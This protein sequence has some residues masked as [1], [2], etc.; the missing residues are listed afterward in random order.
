MADLVAEV[1]KE[2]PIRLAHLLPAPLP[3]S[4]IGFGDIDR[5]EAVVVAGQHPGTLL[6]RLGRIRKKIEDETVGSL[7]ARRERQRSF[8]SV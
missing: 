2:R 6:R 3:L 8:K 4:I 5:D 1:S 7:P